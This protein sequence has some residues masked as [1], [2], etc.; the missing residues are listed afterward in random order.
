MERNEL[1]PLLRRTFPQQRDSLLPALHFLQGE[2]GHL[3]QWAL[4]IVGWHLR[5]PASEV[6]G[7]A[8]SY[9]ELRI[10]APGEHILRVCQGIGCRYT[11]GN[12]LLDELITALG[13][14]PGETSRDGAV[15]LEEAACGYLCPLA[16][17]A[18]LDGRWIGHAETGNILDRIQSAI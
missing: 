13:I 6:Y 4:Q 1:R 2:L 11:G 18:Q 5:I 9:T 10:E 14:R 15:T 3:P 12:E 17:V 7:A 16:P 8:T